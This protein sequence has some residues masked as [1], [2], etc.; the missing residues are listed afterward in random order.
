MAKPDDGFIGYDEEAVE[1]AYRYWH[2][3]GFSDGYWVGYEDGVRDEVAR[4][5]EEQD[6]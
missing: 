4:R 5:E 2:S 3:C 1:E 6:D